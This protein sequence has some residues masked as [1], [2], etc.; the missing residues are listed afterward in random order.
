MNFFKRFIKELNEE[1][2]D[3]IDLFCE[4]KKEEKSRLKMPLLHIRING[5]VKTVFDAENKKAA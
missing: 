5:K 3:I 4:D 1:V 2:D